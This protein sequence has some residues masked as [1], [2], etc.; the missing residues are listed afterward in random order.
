MAVP[1][2]KTVKPVVPEIYAYTTPEVPKHRGWTKIGYTEQ[3]VKKRI[4]Q[5]TH[6]AGLKYNIEWHMTA[7]YE[8]GSGDTF[9]DHDFH[10]YL[11]KLN[12]EREA[13][14]EWFRIQPREAKYDLYEF[15]ESRGKLEKESIQAGPYKLRAEQER[16]VQ[17]TVD[18]MYSHEHGEFLWNAKPR[19]GKTLTVYDLVMRIHAKRV[20]VVTN[21]PAIANSWYEDYKK[22]V[23]SEKYAFVSNNSALREN[24]DDVLDSDDDLLVNCDYIEFES[25]Q[26]LK[27]SVYFGGKFDKYKKI[28]ETEWDLLVID[29]AHEG[30]DTSKTE[31]AFDHVHTKFTLHLSGTPFKALAN[32]K[33]DED[34]IYNWTYADE[35]NAKVTWGKVHD[36]WDENPYENLPQLN[37]YTYQMSE[38]IQ[39]KVKK[40]ICINDK[41]EEYAFDLNEFFSVSESGRFK[42]EVEVNKFLDALTTNEKYPFST[43]ELRNELKHTVWMMD[44]VD[45]VTALKRKLKNHPVFKDYEVI[46]ATGKGNMMSEDE[47]KTSYDRVVKAIK[48]H[49]KTITL[50]V[51]QLTTGITIPEWT[52]VLMLSNLSSPSLYMQAAFRAQNPCLFQ[53]GV[54]H[55][56][57]ERAYVFDFD[58]ARTLTVYEKFANDLSSETADGKGSVAH[59]EDNIK[60]LLNFFPVIGEDDEGK[61]I[62]LDAA[63]VLSIPRKI[64]SEEVVSRGFMS[65]FLFQNISNIFQAPKVVRDILNKFEAYAEPT[66]NGKNKDI[67]MNDDTASDLSLD[68]NGNVVLSQEA[69]MNVTDHIFGN[70]CF[71]D[72]DTQLTD[73]LDEYTYSAE[74]NKSDEDIVLESLKEQFVAKVSTPLV[75]TLSDYDPS[76][77]KKDL[78]KMSSKIENDISNKVEKVYRDREIR[79]NI[80][81]MELDKKLDAAKS[82]EEVIKANEEASKA[83]EQANVSMRESLNKIAQEAPQN[84]AIEVVKELEINKRNK[85]KQEIEAGVRDHLRGFSRTVPLFLMAYGHKDT[86]LETFEIGIPE[87]VFL[88]VT[89]ITVDEFKFLRDGGNIPDPDTGEETYYP[90]HLFDEMVFNDSV[91][92]F[93]EKKERL[94]NYF[95]ALND[96]DIFDYIPPQKTNQVFTPKA[97]VVEMVDMLEKENPGCFDDPDHTFADLYMKSGQYIAEIVKRLFNSKHMQELYTDAEIRLRHIFAKQVYG[98]APTEIIGRICREYVLG[99]SD[100]ITIT[101]DHLITLDAMEYADKEGELEKVLQE[102]FPELCE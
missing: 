77:K 40:G 97:V 38:A 16:A 18:Y 33:F 44:R 69:V 21:R 6:T 47:E 53:N 27:G 52:A 59:R 86:T 56:R 14:T 99:F 58:P 22:F 70:K 3:E 57:K 61:M 10:R 4:E 67:E 84:A 7:M 37:M 72:I 45:S 50:T 17:K 8:D 41:F 12:I 42:H 66:S 2:I 51:G 32:E 85:T 90:G 102:K 87:D 79:N 46:E 49:D 81:G 73:L 15:K 48:E 23:G 78:D 9:K 55:Y 5:Q 39:E 60:Q 94:S 75:V 100:E 54:E 26:D 95:N 31:V 1:K 71:E 24:H 82:E 36:E 63:Q 65:N 92:L 68:E 19:F 62:E 91:Q 101:E 83:Y 89:S 29:E 13:G 43:E 80:I 35:Q 93:M 11:R 28:S 64:R 30:V 34:A 98:L 76:M 74:V 20:L 88:D 25:L 96:E